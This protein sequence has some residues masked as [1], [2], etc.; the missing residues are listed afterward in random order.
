MD[1]LFR[2]FRRRLLLLGLAVLATFIALIHTT[3]Y[4][5]AKKDIE[6]HLE[7]NAKGIAVSIAQALSM[8]IEEYKAFLETGNVNSDY[9]HKMQAYFH[10][11]KE[12]SNVKF[13]YTERKVDE[14][15]SEY[16]L[17][18][19]PIGSPAFS[20]PG[21]KEENNPQKEIVYST[22]APTA[23]RADVFSKWGKLL[24]AYAPIFDR[25]GEVLGVVGVDIDGTHIYG[26]LSRLNIALVAIY[27]FITALSLTSIWKFSS[28]ILDPLLK[29]KMTG[30]YTKRYFESFLGHEITHSV[31]ARKD[32]ALMMFDLDHFKNINDTYGHVF[33]DKVLTTI[34]EIIKKSLRPT[35][36]FVR[37]GGEEFIA[38]IENT[39]I[40]HVLEAAERIRSSIEAR[41]IFNPE[42]NL[43]VNVTISI[44]V[45]GLNNTAISPKELVERADT[46]LYAAKVTRNTVSLYNSN[47]NSFVSSIN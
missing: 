43:S 19:E 26:N 14:K 21:E 36:Y 35:D 4:L 42:K 28:N 34:S 23:Y 12:V 37:Y 7:R 30:A 47:Q 22:K 20:P 11:I 9:Y 25:D 24:G 5:T 17:D 40:K 38:M 29:D 45:A 39:D 3:V 33:G 46:A 32:L 8:D 13:I 2:T 10:S 6:A 16:E 41:Q 44:G 15:T 27:V 1:K 31:R 18:A